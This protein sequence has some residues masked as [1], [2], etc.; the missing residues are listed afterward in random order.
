MDILITCPFAQL[1]DKLVARCVCK[2]CDCFFDS[3]LENS[4]LDSNSDEE[5]PNAMCVDFC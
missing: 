5:S 2:M 1:N 4:D 3:N